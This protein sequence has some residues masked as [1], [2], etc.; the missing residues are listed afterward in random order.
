MNQESGRPVRHP[1]AMLALCFPG[2]YS[3]RLEP[4]FL[5]PA[6]EG[7]WESFQEALCSWDFK[8]SKGAG[9]GRHKPQTQTRLFRWVDFVANRGGCILW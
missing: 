9:R 5:A 2:K 6:P 7:L 1:L 8:A 3:P 4:H